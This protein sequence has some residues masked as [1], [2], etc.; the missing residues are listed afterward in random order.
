MAS[1]NHPFDIFLKTLLLFVLISVA[2]SISLRWKILIEKHLQLLESAQRSSN[3]RPLRPL[4]SVHINLYIDSIKNVSITAPSGVLRNM[5]VT[6]IL[7]HF[8]M[9]PAN[10][11]QHLV[12]KAKATQHCVYPDRRPRPAHGLIGLHA[13]FEKAF[14]RSGNDFHTPLLHGCSLLSFESEH[15]DRQSGT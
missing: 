11:D 6:G 5:P 14:G 2:E 12:W 10:W 7:A 3:N 1:T 4:G 15:V 8:T 9:E 13:T